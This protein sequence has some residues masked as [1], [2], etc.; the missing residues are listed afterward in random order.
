MNVVLDQAA[1]PSVH[2]ALTKRTTEAYAS[3]VFGTPTFVWNKEI[4][5]GADRLDVLAWKVAR[6]A[7]PV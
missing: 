4:F 7:N 2:Q 6:A 3:G 1:D 5:Y